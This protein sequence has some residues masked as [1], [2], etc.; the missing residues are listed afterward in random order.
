MRVFRFNKKCAAVWPDARSKTHSIA[1]ETTIDS[2]RGRRPKPANFNSISSGLWLGTSIH[3][4][5]QVTG[6]ALVYADLWNL[7][8]GLDV[9]TITK[10]VRNV[11]MI[12]CTV[13]K[14]NS[15]HETTR[16]H[17]GPTTPTLGDW[18]GNIYNRR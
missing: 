14:Y 11:F 4:T 7:T 13:H 3:D 15:V 9:A 5:S 8:L 17:N 18:F 12:L 1:A 16:F 10:L 2:L 6:A